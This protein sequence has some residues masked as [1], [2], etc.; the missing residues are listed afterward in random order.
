MPSTSQADP[1]KLLNSKDPIA[2]KLASLA[3]PKPKTSAPPKKDEATERLA[4]EKEKKLE[5]ERKQELRKKKAEA[6]RRKK[7]ALEK[8]KAALEKKRKEALRKKRLE[9]KRKAEARRKAAERRKRRREQARKR[10]M[11]FEERMDAA[12]KKALLDKDPTR[13]NSVGGS[14]EAPKKP[15]KARGATAGAAEGR[16]DRNTSSQRLMVGVMMKSAVSKCW[17]INTGAEGIQNIVVQVDIRLRRDGSL[18]EKPVLVTRGRGALFQDVANA[19][20][21]AVISCAPYDHLPQQYYEGVWD[22]IR[23]TFDP[24]KMY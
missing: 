4:R 16:D 10:K 15:T 20:I 19:A 7:A 9:K 17:S 2:D 11:S 1:P 21:R 8:K 24:R 14:A 3:E 23:L 18:A 6:A 5:L 22:Y 13:R 12:M